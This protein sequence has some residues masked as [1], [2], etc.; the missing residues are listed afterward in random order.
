M[1]ELCAAYFWSL[2]QHDYPDGRNLA[3]DRYPYCLSRPWYRLLLAGSLVLAVFLLV[4]RVSPGCLYF[5]FSLPLSI[6]V[7]H[8][9]YLSSVAITFVVSLIVVLSLFSC[10]IVPYSYYSVVISLFKSNTERSEGH[11]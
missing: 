10:S 7:V 4:A 2:L 8:L 1:L 9:G 11:L 5:S 3:I 6:L